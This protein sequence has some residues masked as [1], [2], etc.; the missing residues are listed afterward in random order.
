MTGS[1]ESFPAQRPTS[2]LLRE[3]MTR[4]T[5]TA[6]LLWRQSMAAGKYQKQDPTKVRVHADMF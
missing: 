1:P 2:K 5:L 6:A 3:R 4:M